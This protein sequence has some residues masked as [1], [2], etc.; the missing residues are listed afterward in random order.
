ML[1]DNMMIPY[2]R[3]ISQAQI[4]VHHIKKLKY[5]LL[6]H[7]AL[8]FGGCKFRKKLGLMHACKTYL[9]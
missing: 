9:A 5:L 4:L 2:S 8:D 3:H 1:T 6:K 7:L